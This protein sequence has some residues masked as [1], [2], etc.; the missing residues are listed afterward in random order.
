MDNIENIDERLYC[1]F[2]GKAND[3]VEWLIKGP[4]A[5]CICNECVALCVQVIEASKAAAPATP[6]PGADPADTEQGVA[7]V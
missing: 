6:A 2:C 3:E 1:S 5:V 4:P 7:N